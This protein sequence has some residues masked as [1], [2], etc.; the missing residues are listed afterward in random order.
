M[1]YNPDNFMW[2]YDNRQFLSQDEERMLIAEHRKNIT[3]RK[4]RLIE[5]PGNA[6]SP[7]KNVFGIIAAFVFISLIAGFVIALKMGY[8]AI[9]VILFG[10]VFFLAGLMTVCGGNTANVNSSSTAMSSRMS[11]LMFMMIG[12][13]IIVP[14]ALIP[15][16]GPARAFIGLGAGLFA[17][18]GLFFSA[19]V[20]M[21]IRR[22]SE[23]YGEPVWACCIG[24]ARSI[25]SHK[26]SRS[27]LRTHEIFEYDY[28]G[29]RWQAI[30]PVSSGRDALLPIGACV[31][32]R[33]HPKKPD[34]PVYAAD[35]RSNLK[36]NIAMLAFTMIFVI[37]GIGLLIFAA[38]GDV[39]DSQFQYENRLNTAQSSLANG[40]HA[41]TDEM[42]WEK[43]GDHETHWIIAKYQVTDKYQEEDSGY[44]IEFSDGM[45]YSATKSVWD[46]YDIGVQFY[47]ISNAD[48]EEIYAVYR[49]EQWEYTGEHSVV[50]Y[51]AD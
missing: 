17:G 6:V 38:V 7:A 2:I 28:N 45:L 12:L 1:R 25:H 51:T 47:Q 48:T 36:E 37:V 11:G 24:Y 26:H 41:L 9:G 10:S 4:M 30:N 3:E 23:Q 21:Q 20:V 31:D 42:I 50:D 49:C 43:I 15:V 27:T 19:D 22:T 5:S 33:I 40:K 44:V 8:P 16:I 46:T 32:V 39:D 34:E 29:E 13:I 14:M 35:N 18:T